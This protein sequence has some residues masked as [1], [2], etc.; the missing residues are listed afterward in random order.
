MQQP[1]HGCEAEKMSKDFEK[2]DGALG[3]GLAGLACDVWRCWARTL[4]PSVPGQVIQGWRADRENLAG[5]WSHKVVQ[6][7]KNVLEV[8]ADS[9]H[10]RNSF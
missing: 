8:H 4:R 10:F 5:R 6:Y 1:E 7:L 9:L 2:D 3:H